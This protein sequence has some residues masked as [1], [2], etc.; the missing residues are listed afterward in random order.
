[1]ALKRHTED[2]GTQPLGWLLI[3]LSIPGMI[4]FLVMMLYNVVDTF[5]VSRLGADAIAA[6]TVVFPFQ[7]INVALGAGS[8]IGVSSL[9]SRL[10]GGRNDD[11]PHL[12]AGQV[13]FLAAALGLITL[14]AGTLAT[15]PILVAF[16]AQPKFIGLS[17][18]YLFIIA[19]G[20]PFLYFQMMSNNLVR[21]SGD[22]LTPMFVNVGSAVFNAVLDPFL[23]FGW[24]PFP[25]MGIAGA[26]LATALS[27]FAGAMVYL[28][29]LPRPHSAYRIRLRNML[30]HW[31]T[32]VQ[33][34]HV[35]APS[36]LMM[37]IGSF[38]I[39]AF[40]WFLGAFGSIAIAAYGLVFRIVQL[41]LMP[42]VGM[43]QGLMPIVGY[44]FG[45]RDFRR[46]WR[47][48]RTATYYATAVTGSAEL[49]LMALAPALVGVFT[50]DAELL[51]LTTS[52][53]RIFSFAL[54]LVGAQMMWIT[55][56]QAMGHGPQAMLLSVLR[57]LGFLVP[58]MAVFSHYYGLAGIW[59]S[60]PLADT[61]AFLATLGGIL[62]LRRRTR[63][64]L[65]RV[66]T[67][68]V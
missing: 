45:A 38:V 30:P 29:Y 34:Y 49:M 55:T 35:G 56:M 50:R 53:I 40:N 46:M 25:E 32:I 9:A 16:G 52:A 4:S 28:L 7:M 43:S 3:R 57:Q 59:M 13:Y 11:G 54:I 64:R 19:F 26:A 14:L 58:L 18:A 36:V 20:T 67:E 33:I 5:W 44:N 39:V 48:V 68:T 1:M 2:L 61:L 60:V 12:V 8:G 27:Q 22:A 51:E 63:A 47:A 6:L 66:Q 41:F 31:R 65:E 42:V 15:N 17:N 10:F 23:I 21:G 62:W 37:F 24:G